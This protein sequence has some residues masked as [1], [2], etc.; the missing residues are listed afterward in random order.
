[1]IKD[2]PIAALRFGANYRQDFDT[3]ALEDLAANM[4]DNGQLAPVIV[5]PLPD[6]TYELLAG[7]RRTRAATLLGWQMIRADVQDVSDDTALGITLAENLCRVNT[8]AVEDARGYAKL[9]SRGWSIE[10]IAKAAGTRAHVV[11]SRLT[12]LS[13]RE[14]LQ[15]LVITGDLGLGYA[16]ALARVGLDRNRQMIAVARLRENPAPTVSWFASVCAELFEQQAQEPMALFMAVPTIEELGRI[17]ARA[18]ILPPLPSTT[19]PPEPDLTT[20]RA[21]RTPKRAKIETAIAFWQVAAARWQELGRFAEARECRGAI[22]AL[23]MIYE[24]I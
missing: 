23:Q 12:L 20:A 1:M 22:A 9:Q 18:D 8:N 11:E 6:D 21:K 15:R 16:Q 14:D 10:R 7:E 17:Q 5:R 4:R 24:T 2:I 13:L 3:R 19:A